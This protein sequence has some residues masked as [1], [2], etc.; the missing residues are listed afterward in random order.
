MKK[1]KNK[2]YGSEKAFKNI[3]ISAELVEKRVIGC[4]TSQASMV[5]QAVMQA[6][7]G[8]GATYVEE[9]SNMY[10]AQCTIVLMEGMYPSGTIASGIVDG[11]INC[12]PV[13]EVV[14]DL[15]VTQINMNEVFYFSEVTVNTGNKM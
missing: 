1:L 6:C 4:S 11:M 15:T 14:T 2:S 7:N 10:K 9:S 8:P 13:A 12:K 3:Y 5:L